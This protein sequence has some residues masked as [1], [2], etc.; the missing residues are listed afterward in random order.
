METWKPTSKH[1]Q[2]KCFQEKL[3]EALSLLQ[4]SKDPK[5][6]AE[7]FTK[8]LFNEVLVGCNTILEEKTLEFQGTVDQTVSLTLPLFSLCEHHFLPFIGK[9]EIAY[10]PDQKIFGLASFRR[11]LRYFSRRPTLQEQLTVQLI[12]YL[13]KTLEPKYLKVKVQAKHYCLLQEKEDPEIFTTEA[14]ISGAT[15]GVPTL[16]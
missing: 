7:R 16:Q 9:V 1:L 10:I 3:E 13:K 11:V 4:V 15:R 5:K 8:V 12:E 6:T 14:Q 2:N